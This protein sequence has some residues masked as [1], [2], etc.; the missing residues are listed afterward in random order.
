MSNDNNL[1]AR[2]KKGDRQAQQII[3]EKYS[4]IMLAICIRY[5]K[6]RMLAEDIMQESFMTIFEKVGQ[7]KD[8]GSFEGWMKKIMVN[9]SLKSIQ[10][11]SKNKFFDIDEINNVNLSN[12]QTDDFEIDINYNDPKSVIEN[13]AFS[14][15]EILEVISTLPDGFRIVFNLY[16]I[17]GYKHKEIAESLGISISTSK[18]QLIRA[19]KHLQDK[20]FKIG[21]TK[22]KENNNKEYLTILK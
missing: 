15:A 18:T 17:E 3:Y 22:Q 20:L 8:L 4:P 14:Q 7:F 10:Q 9:A 19:R 1:I 12:L 5:V 11:S 16:A 6:D 13:T 21:L 2:C